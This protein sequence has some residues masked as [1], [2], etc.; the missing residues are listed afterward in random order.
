MC[1]K[2]YANIF[3]GGSCFTMECFGKVLKDS[4][5]IISNFISISL[6]GC[7]KKSIF[8]KTYFI[9]ESDAKIYYCQSHVFCSMCLQNYCYILKKRKKICFL[10]SGKYPLFFTKWHN[11]IK[12]IVQTVINVEFKKIRNENIEL[13]IV[14]QMFL[15]CFSSLIRFSEKNIAS[16]NI[17]QILNGCRFSMTMMEK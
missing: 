15:D 11:I 17:I 10:L 14:H 9:F 4:S 3:L 13:T 1:F 5:D 6:Y 8:R 2:I 12:C 7:Q 16:R